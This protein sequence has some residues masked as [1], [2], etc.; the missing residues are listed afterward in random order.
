[1]RVIHQNMTPMCMP[2]ISTADQMSANSSEMLWRQK[3]AEHSFGQRTGLIRYKTVNQPG[4][5]QCVC[6]NSV[7]TKKEMLEGWQ[8]TIQQ[9]ESLLYSS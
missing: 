3:K 7:A 2:G 8:F 5:C 6:G 9:A 1:M 4:S